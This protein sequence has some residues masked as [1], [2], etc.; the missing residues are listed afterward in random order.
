MRKLAIN[1]VETVKLAIRQEI[2]SSEDARYEHRLHALLLI[3]EGMSA[4]KVAKLFGQSPRTIQYWVNR[5]NRHGFDGLFETS[6]PGRPSALDEELLAKVGKDL[7]KSPTELGYSQ[8]FWDGKLLSHH[9]Q[10]VY[11]VELGVRQCQ[12]LFRK[13]GFR[14]RKPRPM[15]ANSDPALKRAFKK[16]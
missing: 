13:L 9:L 4:N 1:N 15:I 3:C 10:E 2:T 6:R 11:R 16:N 5:F 12:R 14:R 8:G 7:R